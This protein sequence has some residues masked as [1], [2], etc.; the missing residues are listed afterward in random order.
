MSSLQTSSA[1]GNPRNKTAL[2]PGHSLMDWIRL[3]NSGTDL[4][5]VKGQ[6]LLVSKEQLAQHN[7]ENDV[8]MCIRGVVY[9]VTRYMDF[10]PG[11]RDELMKGAGQD[12]TELFNKV[13]PWVNYESILQKCIV[14][15]LGTSLPD[16][17][18]FLIPKKNSPQSKPK[19]VPSLQVPV[20]SV[21]SARP[22][23]PGSTSTT[24]SEPMSIKSFYS[25]DWFQQLNFVCFV[26]YLKSSSCCK[27]HVTLNETSQEL[28]V[29][30]NNKSLVLHLEHPVQWPCQVKVNLNVGK[31][32][33]QLNKQESKLWKTH[34]T[35]SN[36]TSVHLSTDST[37]YATVQQSTPVTLNYPTM[38]L[39]QSE[40][41][42]HNVVYLTFEY[43]GCIFHYVPLGYH[44]HVRLKVDDVILSKPYTP[45]E[46][47]LNTP[48]TYSNTISFLIKHY[49]TGLL[50]PAL[51]GLTVGQEVEVSPPEGSFDVTRLAKRK[52]LVLIA[53]G[54]GLTPMIP[55][56]NWAVQAQRYTVQMLFFN[57]SEEDIIWRDQLD[58]FAAEN[59][60]FSVEHILSEPTGS[61]QSPRGRICLDLLYKYIPTRSN[62]LPSDTFVCVCGPIGFNQ[63]TQEYLSE[64]NYRHEEDYFCFGG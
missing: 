57:R 56:V 62:D 28:N 19:P 14:G 26:F 22:I 7:K 12:A 36:I 55:L 16:E 58:K 63:T 8:W 45:V 53:A 3:G 30:I 40:R 6:R 10:H 32:Q 15:K 31:L 41:V 49:E 64:L 46:P 23:I 27:F 11:G 21:I 42:T 13:H 44:V 20:K 50:S 18:P 9:N 54:T 43:T 61:W 25:M 38:R 1:T 17:N 39:I 2:K 34:S 33:L 59:S 24:S 29:V 51:A 48:V 60:K 52:K 35:K 5:G 47:L 37:Q 4:T